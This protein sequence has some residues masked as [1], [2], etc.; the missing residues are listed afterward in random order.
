MGGV[1]L[2]WFESYLKGRKQSVVINETLSSPV[3]VLY[4]VPQG[5]VLVPKLFTIHTLPIADIA[6]KYN[7]EIHLY[8]DDTQIYIT[9]RTSDNISEEIA[10]K[11]VQ[12]CIAA[13]KV[14][15]LIN[16]L[17]LNDGKTEFLLIASPY[18]RKTITTTHINIEN[19][20]VP[21]STS[22]RNLG[23][24]FDQH[25]N[26]EEHIYNIRRSCFQ[27]LK[28]ISD[29]RKYITEDAT[30]QLI[31]A[32]ITSGLDNGNSLLYG[33]PTSTISHLQKI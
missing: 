27:H 21:S 33:L 28:R 20:H 8:A 7:L 16:K 1:A 12:S 22:A 11:L 9:F 15:M 32:L 23:I 10:I 17:Q 13:I 3:D 5:S 30:K 19:D 29:I 18:F 31:H 25:M 26:F 4:G 6:R 14:W 24:V 2:K